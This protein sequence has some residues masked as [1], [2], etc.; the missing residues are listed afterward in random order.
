VAEVLNGLGTC[1]ALPIRS[2]LTTFE[3]GLSTWLSAEW[4]VGLSR[5]GLGGRAGLGLGWVVG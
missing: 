4:V 1:T 5:V 3:S 2:T